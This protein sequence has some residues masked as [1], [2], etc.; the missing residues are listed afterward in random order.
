MR[1]SARTRMP[2]AAAA[3]LILAGCSP[4]AAVPTAPATAEATVAP[5]PTAAPV[6]PGPTLAPVPTV[7]VIADAP[8]SGITLQL[9]A[10]GFGWTP[11]TLSAPAG[12]V[13]HVRIDNRDS[14]KHDFIVSS[15]AAIR[16]RI[17]AS[18][19]FGEGIYTYDIPGLPAGSYLFICSLHPT[20][21]EGGLTLR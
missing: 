11:T 20:Y 8:D 18:E 19:Q 21:M 6:T 4:S 14:A 17:F 2:G 3:L 7:S 9:V 1:P 10:E 15:D 13:W 16:Q 12:K 5:E